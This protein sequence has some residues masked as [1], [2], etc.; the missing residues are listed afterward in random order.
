VDSGEGE[1]AYR[2]GVELIH[3]KLHD[4]LAQAA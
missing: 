3:G 4:L 2:K 1:P